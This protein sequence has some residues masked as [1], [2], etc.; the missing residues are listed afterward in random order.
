MVLTESGNSARLIAKYRP[1]MPI[2]AVTSVPSVA[3]QLQGYVKNCRRLVNRG[4]KDTYIALCKLSTT[5]TTTIA[6]HPVLT[7]R[8]SM[9]VPSMKGTEALVNSAI[10][11]AVADGLCKAGD[12]VVAVHG[13]VE[14]AAGS[15]CLLRVYTV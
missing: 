3:R 6:D 1:S 4:R 12:R 14:A 10:Q 7:Y 13:S 11:K 15:T 8:C 9:L 5:T 2:L